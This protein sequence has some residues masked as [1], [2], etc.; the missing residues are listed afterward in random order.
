M[1]MYTV[2][3]NSSLTWNLFVLINLRSRFWVRDN[4]ISFSVWIGG[5][6]IAELELERIPPEILANGTLNGW[7]DR[8]CNSGFKQI[9]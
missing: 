3:V 4:L 1:S 5:A 7:C 8:A 6:E 2:R 9:C